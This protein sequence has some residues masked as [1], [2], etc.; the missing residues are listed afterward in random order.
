M[1]FSFVQFSY[2]DPLKGIQF[3]VAS[4]SHVLF[5]PRKGDSQVS[6]LDVGAWIGQASVNVHMAYE[7][8]PRTRGWTKWGSGRVDSWYL[9]NADGAFNFLGGHLVIS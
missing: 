5:Q 1:F 2:F 6:F 8:S 7:G 4:L 9:F 3:Q